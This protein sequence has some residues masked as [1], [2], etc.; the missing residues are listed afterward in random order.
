METY[1]ENTK[2]VNRNHSAFEGFCNS[3]AITLSG[4][5]HRSTES[6]TRAVSN[7]NGFL[8]SV[9]RDGRYDRREY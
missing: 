3:D 4:S 9:I 2:V 8:D 1:V 7:R 5:K 6:I